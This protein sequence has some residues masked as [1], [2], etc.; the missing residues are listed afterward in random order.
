M[1]VQWKFL[2]SFKA[3][4]RMNSLIFTIVALT[5]Q[6]SCCIQC[7]FTSSSQTLESLSVKNLIQNEGC[8]N[9]LILN[10]K[11][12]ESEKSA[13]MLLSSLSSDSKFP[14]SV[15]FF[16]RVEMML[17]ACTPQMTVLFVDSF[18]ALIDDFF[19]K[20][21]TN[22][23]HSRQKLVIAIPKAMKKK[24]ENIFKMLW[25]KFIYDVNI[26]VQNENL[27]SLS[28]LTFMPFSDG[29]CNNTST[30]MVNKFDGETR[31][32]S[33]GINFPRKFKNL[34]NCSVNVGTLN[35]PP[36]VIVRDNSI[37]GFESLIIKEVGIR[38]NFSM[39]I[40]IDPILPKV[41]EN[42]SSFGLFRRMLEGQVDLTFGSLAIQQLRTEVFSMTYPH[43]ND[44]LIVVVS[45]KVPI[46]SIVKL[47]LPF[48]AT[49]WIFFLLVLVIAVL[50]IFAS[51]VFNTFELFFGE[52]SKTP[53]MNL[54]ASI[55]GLSQPRLPS[56]NAPRILLA[57][58][59]IFCLILRS[60]YA[61]ELFRIIQSDPE[62]QV[63][64]FADLAENN[65][66]LYVWEEF[67]H[68][69]SIYSHYSRW[70]K[71]FSRVFN[72]D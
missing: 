56:S 2:A 21:S 22:N 48:K 70:L 29:F 18:E 10:L 17:N 53:V 25:S 28:M 7:Q 39:N 66:I 9:V 68:I 42:G 23:F 55:F 19:D 51:Q 69:R 20:L 5:C 60:G 44:K 67:Y 65:F 58:F 61:G 59:L 26:L 72:N 52:E 36:S 41:F 8:S 3:R 27:S 32:W 11:E 54:F 13:F 64:S 45:S 62:I 34:Q 12:P 49:V 57:S 30:I 16:T 43:S 14:C 6:S 63:K 1:F 47:L 35:G 4:F 24:I 33:T 40:I 50:I 38:L 71:G 31:K 37:Y 46:G 15:C